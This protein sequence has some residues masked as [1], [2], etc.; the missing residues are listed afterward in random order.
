MN[1]LK[2][3]KDYRS[4]NSYY[5][6]NILKLVK[7]LLPENVSVIEFSSR[8][9]EILSSIKNKKKYGVEFNSDFLSQKH[10]DFSIYSYSKKSDFAKRKYDYILLS[11]TLSEI[12]DAQN[13]IKTIKKVSKFDSKIIVLSYNLLW[14]PVLDIA[15]K[16]GL[17][18]PQEEPNWFNQKD[19]DNMFWLEDF[20]KVKSGKKFLFPFKIPV[21]SSFINKYIA[22]LPFINSLCLIEFSVYKPIVERR[23]YSV[24]IVIPA[25]NE[26]GHMKKVLDIIPNLG[27][28]TEVIFVEGNST[29]NTYEAIQNEI[30]RYKG[31]IETSLYKQKGKGKGDAVRLGFNKCKNDILMILD[32]DLTVP[33]DDLVKFYDAIANDKAEFIMGTR[34]IYPMEKQAMRLLNMYG[35]YFFG[36]IFSYLLDQRITDTLCGTKVMTKDNYKKIANNRSYFGDFDPFGDFDLIFGAS[37]LNLK[38]AEIPIRYRERVYGETNISRFSHGW[39]LLQMTAFAAKKLKFN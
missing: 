15:E 9:G 30:K 19:I 36:K 25:R 3:W 31:P 29:D 17:K 14:K 35:N 22:P 37:K 2:E 18:L 16:I 27:K 23:E 11:D 26:S 10:K 12:D 13:L 38:I 24:S 1:Q 20:Q 7:F 33:P 5:H 34:L 28:K 4:L 6:N 8:G 21:I 39:L 32:A